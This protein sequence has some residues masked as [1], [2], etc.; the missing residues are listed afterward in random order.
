MGVPVPRVL[1]VAEDLVVVSVEG[2]A[3]ES[4]LS[5][6]ATPVRDG[7]E[8]VRDDD[9][10]VGLPSVVEPAGGA[11]AV[12]P[13]LS[14]CAENI[15]AVEGCRLIEQTESGDHVRAGIP[16]CNLVH[17]VLGTNDIV[18]VCVP[19]GVSHALTRVVEAVLRTRSAVELEHH[20]ETVVAGPA[21]CLVDVG[22]LAR[23]VGLAV[24]NVICPV[25]DRK[26]DMV[27][28]GGCLSAR[29]K[30]AMER[31]GHD[32]PAICLKSSSVIQVSQ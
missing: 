7:L 10:E 11:V 4:R 21:D 27:K 30:K 32:L 29:R 28:T 16:V 17:D 22:C 6:E 19:L 9:E 31:E 12:V 18:P 15:V 13:V 23:D 20:L 14:C 26:A 5:H 3:G 24:A 2:D 25:T 8:A 1:I